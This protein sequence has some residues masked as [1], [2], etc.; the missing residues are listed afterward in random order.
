[1]ECYCGTD[2]CA[3][4]GEKDCGGCLPTGGRPF[5]GQCVAAECVRQGGAQALAAARER[6]VAEFNALGIHGLHLDGLNL[7]HGAFVNLEYPLA[8]GSRV[9]LLQDEK[10]LLGE[11][12]RGR[13]E[14]TLFR[15]GCG[16]KYAACLPIRLRRKRSR[17]HSL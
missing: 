6:L 8:N 9:K 13:G 10:N 1:M 3:S 11:S 14:R 7:L 15:R 4:C 5:G 16:R 17:D 2:C 12:D